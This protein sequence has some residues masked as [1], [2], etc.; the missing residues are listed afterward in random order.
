MRGECFDAECLGRVMTAEQ[1]IQAEFFG[2]YGRPMRRF[3]CDE[4]VDAFSGDS[5]DL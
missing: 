3:A 1:K 4:C 5:M 2:R